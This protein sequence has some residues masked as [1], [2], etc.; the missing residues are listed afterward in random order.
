MSIIAL[1]FKSV[2]KTMADAGY[3]SASVLGA[4]QPEEPEQISE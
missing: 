4:H 3:G 2:A 1:L